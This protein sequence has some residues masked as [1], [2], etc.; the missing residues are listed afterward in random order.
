MIEGVFGY[1][2]LRNRL[3]LWTHIQSLD[4]I[5][6]QYVTRYKV[7]QNYVPSI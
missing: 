6:A 1:T 7:L 4:R 3:V 2:S 5:A